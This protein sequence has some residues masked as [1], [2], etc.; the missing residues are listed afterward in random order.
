MHPAERAAVAGLHR[1]GLL[2]FTILG[3]FLAAAYSAVALAVAVRQRIALL[4]LQAGQAMLFQL[5]AGLG[6]L[7]LLACDVVGFLLLGGASE[8]LPEVDVVD[9]FSAGGVIV[10]V[11]W[12]ACIVATPVWYVWTLRVAWRATRRSERGEI[13]A[14]PFFG[15]L[16]WDEAP[17]IWKWMVIEPTEKSEGLES[18]G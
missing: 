1:A 16:V 9:P 10:I 12:L 8:L 7:V 11:L 4:V 18:P 15:H 13:Y 6:L 2:G 17:R 3:W 5:A 14:Y